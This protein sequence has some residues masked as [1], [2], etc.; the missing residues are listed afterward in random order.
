MVSD[1]FRLLIKTS[2]LKAYEIA[3]KAGIHPTTLSKISCGIEKVKSDDS[4]VL[5]VAQ[6]LGVSADECFQAP[7]EEAK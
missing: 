6:V 1:K 4:R 2:P 5:A 7:M 3:H